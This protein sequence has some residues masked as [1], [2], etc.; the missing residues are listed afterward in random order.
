MRSFNGCRANAQLRACGDILAQ[1]STLNGINAFFSRTSNEL[2]GIYNI[3][4]IAS[5]SLYMLQTH[6]YMV[7]ARLC[8]L[9]A[10][11]YMLHACSCMSQICFY[12]LQEILQLKLLL[13]TLRKIVIN[14]SH[15]SSFFCPSC[16][17][18]TVMLTLIVFV[19]LRQAVERHG[20]PARISALTNIFS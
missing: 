18:V 1:L 6:I 20:P 11:S 4:P 2:Q 14:A 19:M 9:Q 5:F 12:V 7:Q 10:R 17:C 3:R 13:K 15:L 8:M 16:Y